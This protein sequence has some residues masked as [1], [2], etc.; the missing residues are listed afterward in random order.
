MVKRKFQ[1]RIAFYPASFECILRKIGFQCKKLPGR[2]SIQ[3]L[4]RG[5]DARRQIKI[6][7]AAKKL[8]LTDMESNS[9]ETLGDYV[10]FSSR[11]SLLYKYW[12]WNLIEFSVSSLQQETF[13]NQA[14]TTLIKQISAVCFVPFRRF[15]RET[16]RKFK[17]N[18]KDQIYPIKSRLCHV[19]VSFC[20][21]NQIYLI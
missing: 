16:G 7:T 8:F 9:T 20:S 1:C 18:K 5:N 13:N 3:Q 11:K 15:L 19:D 4:S 2:T 14:K 10:L 21:H 17:S 12:A 6:P